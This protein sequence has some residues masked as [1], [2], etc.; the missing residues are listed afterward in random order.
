MAPARRAA[1]R[2]IGRRRII[3]IPRILDRDRSLPR[4]ELPVARV[5]R[6]QHAIEQVHAAR[7]RR[8]E[9]VRRPGPHQVARAIR[10]QPIRHPLDDVVHDVRRLA[11][12]QAADG[13]GI[14][15]DL[16][17]ALDAAVA[18]IRKRAALHDAELDLAW[19]RPRHRRIGARL[20]GEEPVAAAPRPAQRALHG[21]LGLRV[22]R[23]PGDALVEDHRDV[24]ADARLDVDDRFRR[25]RERPAVEVRLEDDAVLRDAAAR[26]EREH[27]VA[28]RVGEDGPVPADERV[29]AAERGDALVAGAHVQVIGVGQDDPGAERVDRVERERLDRAARADRHE[30][31]RLDVPVRQAQSSAAGASRSGEDLEGEATSHGR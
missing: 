10:R 20:K 16:E 19:R 11:D 18:Q 12:R 21:R 28:A 4:E 13:I 31:R 24:G 23:R 29:Q 2:R 22:G 14:E 15:A 8:H 25:E 27:L 17:R 6:R 30:R 3:R 5:A 26:G 7:D 1:A 9:V